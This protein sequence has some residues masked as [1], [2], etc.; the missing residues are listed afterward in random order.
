MK[1]TDSDRPSDREAIEATAAAWLAERGGGLTLARAAEFARWRT[2]DPRH[3]AAVVRLEASWS[4]LRD[5]RELRPAGRRLPDPDLLAPA[6]MPRRVG[7]RPALAAVAMAASLVLAVVWW[8]TRDP[9]A[10]RSQAQHYA[11]N[12]GAYQEVTLEDGSL[13][14]LNTNSEVTVS[15]T[16]AE[17]RVRLVRG[18][19][20][21][22]VAKNPSR[23][24]EVEAGAVAVRAVGTAF[25]VRVGSSDIEVLVTEGKVAVANPV[26]L[27]LARSTGSGPQAGR[28]VAGPLTEDGPDAA[29]SPDAPG[30]Q[31]AV[32]ASARTA[33]RSPPMSPTLVSAYERTVVPI[34]PSAVTAPPVVEKIGP[35]ALR[36]ALAW[37]TQR[38]NFQDTPLAEVVA[39]FNRR[40]AVQIELADDGLATLPV[41]GS[42]RADNVDTFVRLLTADNEIVAERPEPGRIVLRKR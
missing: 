42:F 15:F 12:N 13:L 8:V 7:R 41:G 6:R 29:A 33:P 2:A 38:L 23:P 36:D 14:E 4:A 31:A 18:E 20:H 24:F 17:R 32:P 27:A 34:T 40:N 19:A 21:F 35:E 30:G 37:R 9:F 5:L 3:E 10:A 22:T 28:G 11:T 26:G 1:R 25:N 16:P 39:Q